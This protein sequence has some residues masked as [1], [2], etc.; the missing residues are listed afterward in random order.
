MNPK[1]QDPRT[2][3]VLSAHGRVRARQRGTTAR[4]LLSLAGLADRDVPAGGG[5]SSVTLSRAGAEEALADGH[6]PALV[7]RLRRRAM[8][9][10]GD[11]ALVT[12]LI[13][14]GRRRRGYRRAAGCTRR[15][16]RHR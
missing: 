9:V 5:C 4:M 2:D 13:P 8:V 3:L 1:H 10:A 11:G 12:I 16:G 6:P 15:Q 14:H 7:E